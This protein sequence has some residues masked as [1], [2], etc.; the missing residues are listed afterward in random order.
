MIGHVVH[1]HPSFPNDIFVGGVKGT[2]R[3]R[4]LQRHARRGRRDH[5]GGGDGE[6]GDHLGHAARAAAERRDVRRGAGRR[7][8]P[9]LQ[10]R[11]HRHDLDQH[12]QPRCSAVSPPTAPWACAM[13]CGMASPSCSAGSAARRARAPMAARH[14]PPLPLTI[15][16][17][18]PG[19]HADERHQS[20]LVARIAAS[21]SARCEPLVSA[22]W[23]RPLRST[24]AGA[25][26]NYMT[27]GIGEVVTWKPSFHPNDPQRD[28]PCR[29]RT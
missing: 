9:L 19:G 4:A 10:I 29:W 26:V 15:T 23:L 12:H 16:G 22:E 6:C 5:L 17:T 3:E 21:G 20:R 13:C 11:R 28:L 7:E 14:G 25:T 27:R 1:M 18:A 24:D 2:A 8:Q